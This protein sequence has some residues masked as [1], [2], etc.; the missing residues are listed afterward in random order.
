[1]QF[2]KNLTYFENF[3]TVANMAVSFQIDHSTE[4]IY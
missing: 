1:M 4:T 2:I 3:D